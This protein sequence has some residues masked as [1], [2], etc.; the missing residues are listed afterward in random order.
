M[1]LVVLFGLGLL[2]AGCVTTK[3]VYGP[4]GELATLIN[5]SDL[6]WEA[7]YEKASE[8]CGTRGYDLIDRASKT[9]GGTVIANTGIV[10][11]SS[12]AVMM[13]QCKKEPRPVM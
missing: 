7:C 2:L 5:C 9:S 6:G 12:E 10:A 8:L 3:E 4:N 13:I 11:V 1:R